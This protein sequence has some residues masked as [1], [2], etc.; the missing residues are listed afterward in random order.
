MATLAF[1][2]DSTGGAE[3]PRRRN[4]L[5]EA[6]GIVERRNFGVNPGSLNL[7]C[8]RILNCV[9]LRRVQCPHAATSDEHPSRGLQ[10]GDCPMLLRPRTN[11]T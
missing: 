7:R 4:E 9:N 2:C 8:S 10:N 11:Q 1:Y 5:R 3:G 6:L